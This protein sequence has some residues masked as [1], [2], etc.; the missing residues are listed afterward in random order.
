MRLIGIRNAF[1]DDFDWVMAAFQR[2]DIDADAL[3]S[4][5]LSLVSF[6]AK[7]SNLA[8]DRSTLIKVIVQMEG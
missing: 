6:A 1:R 2:G 5:Q 3:C 8:A 7:F 4:D